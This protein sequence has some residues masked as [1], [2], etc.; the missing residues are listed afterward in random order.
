MKDLE[1]VG[2]MLKQFIEN[3]MVEANKLDEKLAEKIKEKEAKQIEIEEI[4][5]QLDYIDMLKVQLN[6]KLDELQQEELVIDSLLEELEEEARRNK[7]ENILNN[8]PQKEMV[9]EHETIEE[10]EENELIEEEGK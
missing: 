6:E 2:S 10:E 3:S 1:K 4:Q 5:Q 8:M 7:L 9:D